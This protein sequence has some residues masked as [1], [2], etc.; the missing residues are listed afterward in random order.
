LSEG[1]LNSGHGRSKRDHSLLEI[2]A[3]CGLPDEPVTGRPPL[4]TTVT[5][6]PRPL[7]AGVT[8]R[9]ALVS[10]T[11]TPKLEQ[12]LGV[13]GSGLLLASDFNGDRRRES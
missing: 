11:G 4:E 7:A 8:G 9:P 5:A 2:G 13:S 6:R 3:H 10:V 1:G 12:D